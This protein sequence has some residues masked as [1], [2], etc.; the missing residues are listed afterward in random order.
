MYGVVEGD[1]A[2]D[3]M[4]I[5][6]KKVLEKPEEPP[7]NL[8]ILPVYVFNPLIFRALEKT[9]YGKGDEKQL[10]DGIEKL[11]E[12]GFEVY[13][14]KLNADDKR[15]DIGTP[16]FYAEALYLSAKGAGIKLKEVEREE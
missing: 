8:S 1:I 16:K 12:W 9:G 14:I 2:D 6:V 10:T 11:I 7:S 3:A 15:L 5:K 4:N 13:A